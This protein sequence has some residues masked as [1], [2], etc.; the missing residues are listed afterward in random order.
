MA[1]ARPALL[2]LLH[3][4]E[5]RTAHNPSLHVPLSLSIR[6]FAAFCYTALTPRGCLLLAHLWPWRCFFP[7]LAAT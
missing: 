7:H 4:L 3:A 6:A 2:A 5:G 1:G